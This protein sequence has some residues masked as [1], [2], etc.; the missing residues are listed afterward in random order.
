MRKM[1]KNITIFMII[2]VLAFEGV[3]FVETTDTNAA[4]VYV[5]P[6]GSKY[7]SYPCGRGS[8][9]PTSLS[10]ALAMG[11]TPC[12]KCGAGSI[13]QS[14]H[15]SSSKKSSSRKKYVSKKNYK[16][17]KKKL[18]LV[19]C[20][21]KKIKVKKY[22]GKVK[23]SSSKKSVA[24]VSKGKI[25]AKKP[26]KATIYA[27]FNGRKLACKVRVKKPKVKKIT[28]RNG[29]FL[30]RND[31]DYFYFKVKNKY[32]NK[33]YRKKAKVKSSNPSVVKVYMEDGDIYW[34]TYDKAGAAM[35]TLKVG[36]KTIS[37][38]VTVI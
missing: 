32:A 27:K 2:F 14:S 18:K 30:N 12:A 13:K 22:S 28:M 11:L 23:W 9:S 15:K 3:T 5:T 20:Q 36:G 26:G 25:K 37:R 16:L 4:T 29:I 7:H 10:N 33:Y 1:I 34:E 24:T 6:T 38:L 8:Y 35:I 19:A 17:S 31:N 21:T